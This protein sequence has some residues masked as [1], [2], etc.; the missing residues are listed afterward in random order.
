MGSNGAIFLWKA[1]NISLQVN[2]IKLLGI[3]LNP[4]LLKCSITTKDL[5]VAHKS[6][7][8]LSWSE[9]ID[10]NWIRAED[11]LSPSPALNLYNN[12]LKSVLENETYH[13]S[14]S[15]QHNKMESLKQ[16]IRIANNIPIQLVLAFID[17]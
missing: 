5:K 17:Y 7:S 15:I 12:G 2:R 6:Q 8:T 10:S 14:K 9:K 4:P 13:V 3:L 16:S 1:I 11:W